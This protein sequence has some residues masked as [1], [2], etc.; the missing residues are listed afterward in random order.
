[1]NKGQLV[2]EVTRKVQDK[3][4]T[5]GVILSFLNEAQKAIAGRVEIPALR[6]SATVYS[7]V[8]SPFAPMPDD[9]QRELFHCY[10]ETDGLRLQTF[11]SLN[12]L[13]G[14]YPDYYNVDGGL[15]GV[16]VEN[17]I[18][19]PAKGTITLTGLPVADETFVV[20][21]QTFTFKALRASAGQV[22]IGGTAA[23][24][25]T[26]IATAINTDLTT[27]TAAASGATVVV[28]SVAKTAAANLIAFTESAT[29]LTVDGD[30]T[31]GGTQLGV[32]TAWLHYAG[33]PT[34]AHEFTLSYFALPDDLS[35]DSDEPSFLPDHLQRPLLV[36]YAV[37]E[38]F[39]EIYGEDDPNKADRVNARYELSIRELESFL[40]PYAHEPESVANAI[41][42]SQVE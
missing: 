3:S 27:V 23:A 15:Q 37:K 13:K 35:A 34:A 28:T 4:Y 33:T 12:L 19:Q 6:S 11:R 2:G 22:T 38:I 9:Y 14:A 26:N 40:G 30:D 10:D 7:V 17:A 1:M 41:D 5:A 31:L 18:P 20:D 42:W 32:K 16:T 25:A 39:D 8:G 21:T 36:N 24:T 29:N